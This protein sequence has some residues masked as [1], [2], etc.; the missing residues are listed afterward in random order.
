MNQTVTI[1][2]DGAVY[3]A[4]LWCS[5]RKSSEI[6]AKQLWRCFVPKPCY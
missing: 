4:F 1:A 6:C 3:R 5:G 2:E